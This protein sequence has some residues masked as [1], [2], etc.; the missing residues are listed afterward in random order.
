MKMDAGR[1]AGLEKL[2]AQRDP[3]GRL[4]LRACAP[5]AFP[6]FVPSHRG[7][8]VKNSIKARENFELAALE[9]P[10]DE[11][12]RFA[13]ARPIVLSDWIETNQLSRAPSKRNCRWAWCSSSRE[14]PG[15]RFQV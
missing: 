1:R 3:S 11:D 15:N 7:Q 10:D 6:T 12:G 13:D 2:E 14:R 5:D 8:V 4:E 9:V